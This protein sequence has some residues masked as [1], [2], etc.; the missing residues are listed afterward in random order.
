[1]WYLFLPWSLRSAFFNSCC[2]APEVSISGVPPFPRYSCPQCRIRIPG[3]VMS[4]AGQ[5][6]PVTG[7]PTLVAC[8]LPMGTGH[9][10]A[11]YHRGFIQRLHILA[12]RLNTAPMTSTVC[13]MACIP[14]VQPTHNL[15]RTVYPLL[16]HHRI[17]HHSSSSSFLTVKPWLC[18]ITVR[19]LSLPSP[20][21]HSSMLMLMLMLL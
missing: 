2:P 5:P 9:L 16:L 13:T 18:L 15:P 14:G 11:Y 8:Q 1:V 21:R 20:Y 19:T 12:E 17:I 3:Q 6:T 10:N 7:R 4:A